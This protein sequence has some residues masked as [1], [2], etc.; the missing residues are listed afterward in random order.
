MTRPRSGRSRP[1][2]A[3]SVAT[4]TRARPSRSACSAWVRSFWVSSPDSATAA[5]PRSTRLACRW[6][7]A[8]RVEQNTSAPGASKKRSRLTTA[9]SRSFGAIAQRAVLDVAVRLALAG[10]GD[11]QRVALVALGERG[12]LL[13]DGRREQQRAALGRRGVEDELEVLAE[14]QVEHLVGLV[15]HDGLAAPRCRDCR[16]RDGRAAGR[17]CRRRCARPGASA[18]CSRRMSMPPTQ[19]TTRAPVGA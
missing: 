6:R 15:E 14:A 11:A 9:C 12:D 19:A 10:G 3:T 17:A 8:S 13:G 7:T 2:A 16:A 18:R 4:Q 5:K 1:R